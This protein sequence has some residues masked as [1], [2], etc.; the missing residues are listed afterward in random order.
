ML[1]QIILIFPSEHAGRLLGRYR[2]ITSCSDHIAVKST[3]MKKKPQNK[4]GPDTEQ[5]DVYI[6]ESHAMMVVIILWKIQQP[7]CR[8]KKPTKKVRVCI[9]DICL[10][11]TDLS[12][13]LWIQKNRNQ[14]EVSNDSS[15]SIPHD[16]IPKSW[17]DWRDERMDDGWM[18]G[19]MMALG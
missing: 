19:W 11:M 5:Q 10:E 2:Q 12:L 8:K 18:D 17:K 16:F 14:S 9:S 1:C 6:Q 3:C 4:P 15:V 7:L 13:M